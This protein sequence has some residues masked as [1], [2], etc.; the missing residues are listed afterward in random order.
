MKG[1]IGQILFGQK[2]GLQEKSPKPTNQ[3]LFP[4]ILME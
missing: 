1:E 2:S 3:L 4:F